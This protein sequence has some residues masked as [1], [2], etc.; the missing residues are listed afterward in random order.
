MDCIGKRAKL[1]PAMFPIF[2]EN[3]TRQTPWVTLAFIAVS[4]IVFLVEIIAGEA[5]E[6]AFYSFGFVPAVMFGEATLPPA[7]AIIPEPV[8]LITHLFLHGSLIHLLG[9]LLYLWVFGNN[10]EEAL[11]RGRFTLFFFLCGA[12]AALLQGVINNDSPVPMVGASGAISGVLGAYLLLFPRAKILIVIPLVIILYPTRLA[13]SWVLGLWFLLQL[14]EALMSDPGQPGIAWWAHFGG[15]AAGL[16]LVCL[17]HR[18]EF[19]LF[20]ETGQPEA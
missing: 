10:V 3:P 16:I 12:S 6:R 1:R 18:R 13:A 2:D 20:G 11:G 4:L 14:F 9:N 5:G 8:T 7:L 15:F 19:P 17:L